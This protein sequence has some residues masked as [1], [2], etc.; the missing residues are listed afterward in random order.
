MSLHEVEVFAEHIHSLGCPMV[1]ASMG[2]EGAVLFCGGKLYRQ[3]AHK[4][5]AL[6]T[7]G[8][9]DAFLTAFL[10]AYL[11]ESLPG[12]TVDEKIVRSLDHAAEF[13]AGICMVHGAFGEGEHYTNT[14][15][16]D[17]NA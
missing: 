10:T 7:L 1:E 2:S 6:D 15:L 16:E 5:D 8:A 14:D 3:P 11:D 4:V 17:P 12:E 9:G 13:A